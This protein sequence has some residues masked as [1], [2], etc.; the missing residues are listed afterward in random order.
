[1]QGSQLVLGIGFKVVDG[2]QI[3]QTIKGRKV[4]RYHHYLLD[5]K[6]QVELSVF[7]L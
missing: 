3:T 4:Y 7:C 2:S 5:Q 6:S 1:M